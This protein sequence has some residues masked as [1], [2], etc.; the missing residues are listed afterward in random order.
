ME[1][2]EKFTYHG[3][4]YEVIDAGKLE[5]KDGTK[6]KVLM[7]EPVHK[8]AL[9]KH[10]SAVLELATGKELNDDM[11]LYPID[12]Q[13]IPIIA[14]LLQYRKL[15]IESHLKKHL[16]GIDTIIERLVKSGRV[17]E[18]SLPE[19]MK[20]INSREEKKWKLFNTKTD[21]EIKLDDVLLDPSGC[22]YLLKK[23]SEP[24]KTIK[25]TSPSGVMLDMA[26]G[27]FNLEWREAKA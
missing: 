19:L 21:K 23:G 17:Q 25:V 2:T 14:F 7:V 6:S 26:P 11:L 24:P 1:G 27:V 16:K 22:P 18:L 4:P 12:D 20:E 8:E 10:G 13:P 5:K 3:I 15:A 9:E